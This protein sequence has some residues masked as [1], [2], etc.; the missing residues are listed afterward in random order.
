MTSIE[1]KYI[2]LVKRLPCSVCDAQGGCEAHEPK[3]GLWFISIAL[4]SSCHRDPVNGLHGQ[5]VM[6]KIKKMDEWDALAV[7]IRQVV[8]F[9]FEVKSDA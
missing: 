8:Y 7:T 1:K 6:W 2:D 9:F 3:Q 5:K 4:C